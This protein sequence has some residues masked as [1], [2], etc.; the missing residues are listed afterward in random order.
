MG[1]PSVSFFVPSFQSDPKRK[2]DIHSPCYCIIVP[3]LLRSMQRLGVPLVALAAATND[4]TCLELAGHQ[5]TSIVPTARASRQVF[6]FHSHDKVVTTVSALDLAHETTIELQNNS[7]RRVPDALFQAATHLVSICTH[8]H[9][10]VVPTGFATNCPSLTSIA[11]NY[12]RIRRLEPHALVNLPQLESMYVVR[13][14]LCVVATCLMPSLVSSSLTHNHVSVIHNDAL[15]NLTALHTLDL[16][17]NELTSVPTSILTASSSWHVLDFSHNQL[18]DLPSG[19]QDA[20]VHGY[21]Y[22][23]SIAQVCVLCPHAARG[24]TSDPLTTI[25]SST[26]RSQRSP[27]RPKSTSCDSL[28]TRFSPSLRAHSKAWQVYKSCTYAPS[29]LERALG[30]DRGYY[31]VAR[32]NLSDNVISVIKDD[33]FQDVER[34]QELRLDANQLQRLRL[35]SLPATLE[36]LELQEN[37]LDLMPDFP[38]AFQAT[39]L[40]FLYVQLF[41]TYSLVNPVRSL[42]LDANHCSNLS[43]NRLW[44]LS[45]NHALTPYPRLE[46]L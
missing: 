10:R 20:V 28:P 33:A 38:P 2:L 35:S 7:L 36:R 21:M 46:T 41:T 22:V 15:R 30:A 31:S 23:R 43:H 25:S 1:T 44:S 29:N 13:A 26:S 3:I 39:R 27:T 8:T 17:F 14:T 32:R 45:T 9:L 37:V 5:L 12:S 42:T 24:S 18:M 4:V 11:L 40:V 19:M 34:L 16:S 6:A